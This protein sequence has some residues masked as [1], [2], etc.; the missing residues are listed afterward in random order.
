MPSPPRLRAV[1]R[2]PPE[3]VQQL[4]ELWTD[5]T[6]TRSS[7]SFLSGLSLDTCLA[8][9]EQLNLPKWGQGKGG[10]APKAGASVDDPNGI[11]ARMLECQMRWTDAEFELRR[12][13]LTSLDELD[14]IPDSKQAAEPMS[15]GIRSI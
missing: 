10:G 6:Q 7:V 14:V 15:W 3:K 8:V 1:D 12:R 13:H 5:P 4:R 9:R 11:A 2:L